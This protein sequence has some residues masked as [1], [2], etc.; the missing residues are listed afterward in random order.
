MIP[1]MYFTSR[2]RFMGPYR[3]RPLVLIAGWTCVTL[4]TSLD[5]YLLYQALFT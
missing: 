3:N 5:L 2:A 4:I 1:L